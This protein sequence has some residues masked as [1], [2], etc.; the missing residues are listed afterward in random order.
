VAG[1]ASMES[2]GAPRTAES[3]SGS[4]GA[5]STS[6]CS[7]RWTAVAAAAGACRGV[8]WRIADRAQP[9]RC[10][11]LADDKHEH[12]HEHEQQARGQLRCPHDGARG[13]GDAAGPGR[14]WDS[15]RLA[16][17]MSGRVECAGQRTGQHQILWNTRNAAFGMTSW[18]WR[19]EKC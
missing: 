12:E 3:R 17:A 18:R 14:A 11:G 10:R 2:A 1:R 5:H 15:H 19:R 9:C 7:R 16:W 8:V 13:R 6:S 4:V